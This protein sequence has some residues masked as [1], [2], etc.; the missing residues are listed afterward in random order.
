M[1]V[2]ALG[3]D[4]AEWS[5]V[6]QL[7]AQGDMPMVGSLIERSR[8]ARIDGAHPRNEY[9]WAEFIAG[10]DPGRPHDWDTHQFDPATYTAF[11]R[12]G[13]PGARFWAGAGNGSGSGEAGVVTLDV[14][15]AT[16]ADDHVAVVG[17]GSA[18]VY[19]P[20][21]SNPAG[22]LSDI[23]SRFGPHPM[24]RNDQIGWHHGR[25][26]ER[27]AAAMER[28]ARMRAP[29]SR[30]LLD[31][32]PDWQLFMTVWSEIHPAAEFLW[33]GIDPGH[34]LSGHPSAPLAGA[35]LRRIFRAVD[36][37][38]RD[39]VESLPPDTAVV[40]F[41]LNGVQTGP[42]DT[43]SGVL[44]PEFLARWYNGR[45]LIAADDVAGWR[46]AGCPPVA[47]GPCQRNG[48]FSA[49]R[50]DGGDARRREERA[51]EAMPEFV[52]PVQDGLRRI[53]ARVAGR[54]LG[55]LGMTIPPETSVTEASL[56][57]AR[58]PFS[59]VAEWYQPMWSS[60]PAFALPSFAHGY[61]RLNVVGREADGL[62]PVADYDAH[63]RAIEHELMKLTS[64]RDGSAVV[65]EV[66]RTRGTTPRE[67]LDPEGPYEDLN[68]VWNPCVD[69]IEHP[70]IGVIGPFPLQRVAGHT[71]N[72]FA[73]VSAPGVAA[74]DAGHR[75]ALELP[76]TILALLG[77]QPHGKTLLDANADAPA[78]PTVAADR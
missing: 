13:Q 31:R 71:Q 37:G 68:V 56:D 65:R 45:S 58:V 10:A 64:P 41:S 8:C 49:R 62:V 50:V 4:A 15:R 52:W 76:A 19:G 61:V 17:W 63:C 54:E 39:L 55:P 1:R 35:A 73:L 36:D 34:L 25:R 32:F 77:A 70:L 28:G 22:L 53:A 43:A 27:V 47:P 78:E 23:D 18:Q 75:S 51:L 20:R 72:G 46:R 11:L 14:P 12:H 57:E 26:I 16:A 59:Q 60:M 42:G 7:V 66:V 30:Y 44:L 9:V 33:H 24:V 6:E 29:V 69:A 48:Y 3:F 38:V 40:L 5:F 2:A 21:S 74:G 67:I